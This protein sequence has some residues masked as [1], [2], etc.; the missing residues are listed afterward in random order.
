MPGDSLSPLLLSI[1]L[2]ALFAALMLLN[3]WGVVI[4]GVAGLAVLAYWL[5]PRDRLG[6][7][8]GVYHHV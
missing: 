2:T 5:W 7:T 4:A 8:A 3:W 1:V 6:Q